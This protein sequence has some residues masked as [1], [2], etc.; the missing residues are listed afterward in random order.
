MEKGREKGISD[1]G[2][3][4]D[5]EC[6][7][8]KNQEKKLTRSR[9]GPHCAHPCSSPGQPTLQLVRKPSNKCSAPAWME[10]APSPFGASSKF[11]TGALK[12]SLP[13][14]SLG[15]ALSNCCPLGSHKESPHGFH[16]LGFHHPEPRHSRI[17]HKPSQLGPEACGAP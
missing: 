12:G 7:I 11:P 6:N 13:S 8:V 2:N 10:H 16:S 9:A 1:R 3:S 4:G 15:Q 17:C 14:C 5:A